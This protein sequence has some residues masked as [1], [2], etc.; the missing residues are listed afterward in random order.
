[1]GWF[2]RRGGSCSFFG[3]Q[4]RGIA[5]QRGK[6]YAGKQ[7]LTSW[8]AVAH[9]NRKGAG[10]PPDIVQ[11]LECGRTRPALKE[12]APAGIRRS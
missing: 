4:A 10:Q 8:K 2:P 12:R 9:E 5:L 7:N 1:M 6:L 3:F 11:A